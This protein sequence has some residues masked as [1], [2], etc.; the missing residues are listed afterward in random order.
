MV[1]NYD[2]SSCYAAVICKKMS[3]MQQHYSVECEATIDYNEMG[4]E[5]SFSNQYFNINRN[6]LKNYDVSFL[7]NI[8]PPFSFCLLYNF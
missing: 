6:I 4:E 2:T 1:K 8:I 5:F 3:V 7:Y